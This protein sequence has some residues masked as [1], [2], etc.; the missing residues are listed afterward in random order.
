MSK[1][2]S[3]YLLE[4]EDHMDVVAQLD[5][6]VHEVVILIFVQNGCL[7]EAVMYL[8]SFFV[9]NA[10]VVDGMHRVMYNQVIEV[11]HIVKE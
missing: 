10:A 3:K 5:N 7:S 4:N 6:V 8:Y 9:H 1:Q 11:D 2:K